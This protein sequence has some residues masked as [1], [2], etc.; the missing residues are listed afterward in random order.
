MYEKEPSFSDYRKQRQGFSVGALIGENAV[1]PR[2][3]PLPIRGR[4]K[5]GAQVELCY[6]GQR[7]R[8]QVCADGSWQLTM[9]PE[10][11]GDAAAMTFL[12]D[13]EHHVYENVIT[14][15]VWLCSG[16]SNMAMQNAD[17]YHFEETL[18]EAENPNIRLF[19]VPRRE[20]WQH[21]DSM[22]GEW[23]E[24]SAQQV[25]HFSA[26]GWHFG[27]ELERQTGVPQGLVCAAVGGASIHTFMAPA[28]LD[29][30]EYVEELHAHG[31]ER[32]ETGCKEL[33]RVKHWNEFYDVVAERVRGMGKTPEPL[34]WDAFLQCTSV[35][36]HGMLEAMM[37]FPFT[38]MLWYQGESECW[39]PHVY[40]QSL[41]LL[42]ENMRRVMGRQDA[43]VFCVQ[44]A[45]YCPPEEAHD[46][47]WNEIQGHLEALSG[48]PHAYCA[49]AFDLGE[50]LD[51]HPKEKLEVGRR[52]SLLARRY[53][54]GESLIASGPLP[55]SI[56]LERDQVLVQFDPVCGALVVEGES[57]KAFQVVLS[58]GSLVRVNEVNQR[59][60]HT[61]ALK[62]PVAGATHL[63]H[64]WERCP[65]GRHLKNTD[66][67]PSPV[68]K[69]AIP[70]DA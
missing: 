24:S 11:L 7:Q 39:H 62:L 55:Q 64:A 48:I 40:P 38:G 42:F 12:H 20:S 23:T 15:D 13:G 27:R 35:F 57:R 3:T 2:E 22:L 21:E 5:P 66:G 25:G 53:H 34:P 36:W 70:T 6:R 44:L 31:I 67:L 28:W 43:P 52:L 69:R 14:G 56:T 46:P 18:R 58:D 61:L 17:C 26:V 68:W 63:V 33:N 30:H 54:Y 29:S 41:R 60:A 59:N 49:P 65:E 19:Y 47:G 50:R 45:S 4:G 1:I 37:P 9:E 10:P 32:F 51:V 16:Q 8:T